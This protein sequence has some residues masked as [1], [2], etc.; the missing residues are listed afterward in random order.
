LLLN[1]I[2][3]FW[4]EDVVGFVQSDW[5][6]KVERAG[7]GAELGVGIGKTLAAL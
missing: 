4:D 5:L 2:V 1:A 3:L 6:L 7:I